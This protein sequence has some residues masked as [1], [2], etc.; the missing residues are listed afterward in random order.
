MR[1][2]TPLLNCYEGAEDGI[3][4]LDPHLGKVVV[5]VGLGP[6]GP[7]KRLLR[8]SSFHY[9]HPVPIVERS[10]I[11]RKAHRCVVDAAEF[12]HD[13][14]IPCCPR[15]QRRPERSANTDPE[16]SYVGFRADRLKSPKGPAPRG[17]D[18]RAIAV[19][20]EDSPRGRNGRIGGARRHK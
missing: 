11:G 10:I 18:P 1:V 4:T 2:E 15:A 17:R 12:G 3:R 19:L 16:N 7:L 13:S 20:L 6:P 9:V 5:F 8:P 14:R